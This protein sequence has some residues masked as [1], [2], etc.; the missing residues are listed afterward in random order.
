[1][2]DRSL[3]QVCGA[4]YL[5]PDSVRAQL[6]EEHNVNIAS[7]RKAYVESHPEGENAVTC[8]NGMY[9]VKGKLQ[10]SAPFAGTNSSSFVS[11]FSSRIFD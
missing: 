10:V 2:I 3:Q 1:M 9:R 5:N 7:H 8:K 4:G 11:T 6:C